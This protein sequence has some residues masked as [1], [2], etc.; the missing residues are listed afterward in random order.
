[1]SGESPGRIPRSLLIGGIVVSMPIIAFGFFTQ[2]MDIA[3]G[4]SILMAA[5][6]YLLDEL[7]EGDDAP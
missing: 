3:L 5:S 1:M 4:G 7:P 6:G 2:Q